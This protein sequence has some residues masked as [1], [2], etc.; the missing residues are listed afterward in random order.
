MGC[1]FTTPNSNQPQNATATKQHPQPHQQNCSTK[2]SQPIEEEHVKEVLKE[3]PISKPQ[4]VPILKPQ[5]KTQL[6]VSQPQKVP[7]QNA[8]QL[9]ET[10][11]NGES[12]S[13]TT[14]VTENPHD[15]ATSKRSNATQNRNR[16]YA[17]DHNIIGGRDRRPKSPARKPEIPVG[18]RPL[19]RRESND[20]RRHSGQ[21]SARRSRSPSRGGRSN[22][23]QPRE[24]GQRIAAVKGV[25]EENDSVS[26]K[27]S[28]ENPHVSLECFIFL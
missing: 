11:S 26:V 10:C 9:S 8:F 14:T 24:S 18:S 2:I 17:V 27:E 5:T 7:I 25:V 1:C 23:R 3:T 16:S 20:L 21:G 13:S 15:E 12:L 28:L 22:V 4:Q 19:R 6:P